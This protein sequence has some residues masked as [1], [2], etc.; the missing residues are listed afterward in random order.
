[1]NVARKYIFVLGV[2]YILFFLFTSSAIAEGLEGKIYY[3]SQKGNNNHL[4]T[5]EKPWKTIQHAANNMESGDTVFVRG[6]IYSEFVRITK[7]GSKADG[8]ITF[9]A[10]A[11]EV[12]ILDGKKIKLS[13]ANRAFFFIED[14]SYIRIEGF[15]LRNLKTRD[16]DLYPAG[17]LVKGGSNHITL[18]NNNIHH[19][20][21]NSKKGNAHG[22]L[23]YGNSPHAMSNITINNNE[24]H[25][26]KLGNSEALTL[27]GN[28][29]EFSITH[30]KVHHNN[31]IGIDIAGHYKAC[32]VAGCIDQARNGTI[33]NNTVFQNSSK[34]NVA[35]KEYSA[36]GIYADGSTQ[37]TIENNIVSQND[38]GI[39]LAS[40]NG[41]KATSTIDV[42]SNII[43]SNKGAGIITGG[44]EQ[45]NGGAI[46]NKI[47]NNILLFNDQS[48]EG[49]GEIVMQWNTKEN[50]ILNNM[51]YS[52]EKDE[53]IQHNSENAID[54][55]YMNN[56]IYSFEEKPSFFTRVK[57][58]FNNLR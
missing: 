18:S 17:I 2:L 50:Q 1:M 37:L 4:G 34:R 15:E 33:S 28:V 48:K 51:I 24:I 58:F 42:I 32:E 36:A 9:Q 23:F 45:T 14:A 44:A 40:E 8:D 13:S 46:G 43:H 7:S 55:V 53:F 57:D 38:F 11:G 49:Y 26:L 3:V 47:A 56:T 19:I 30:N 25:H 35:Y 12:P 39:E 6:G 31:N 27:S 22:I 16:A 29:K 20:E 41:K 5:K 52:K 54:N 21:N 10:F